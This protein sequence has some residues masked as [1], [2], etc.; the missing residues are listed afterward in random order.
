MES[1]ILLVHWSRMVKYYMQYKKKGILE[2][3]LLKFSINSI[4]NSK[5]IKLR[6]IFSNLL[7]ME[8]SHLVKYNPLISAN[9]TLRENT[10]L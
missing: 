5:N 10:S 3:S 2:K 1:S 6:F 4:I 8:S 7:W 9:R